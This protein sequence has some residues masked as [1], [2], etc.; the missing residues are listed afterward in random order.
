MSTPV[1]SSFD[2]SSLGLTDVTNTKP[3]QP[4]A[5]T[6]A[7][8]HGWVE[9]Q[10]YDYS[11]YQQPASAPANADRVAPI[12]AAEGNNLSNEDDNHVVAWGSTAAK[13]EWSDEFGEIGPEDKKLEEELFGGINAPRQSN[14]FEYLT[15][16]DVMQES[17]L[18]PNPVTAFANAGFHPAIMANIKLAGY[19]VPT[20]IQAYVIPTVLQGFDVVACAQTGSGKTAAFLLPILSKLMGKAKKLCAPKPSKAQL[21]G[22]LTTTY[23]AEPLVLIIAPTREL[24]TQIFVE[25]SRFCYRSMLR[26]CVVYGGVPP[27]TQREDL[28]KGCDILIG[29]PGR[30]I[31]FMGQSHVLSLHRLK[32]TVI[33]EADE[34]LEQ[35][36]QEDLTKLLKGGDAN[37]DSDHVFM[38]F[39]ATFPAGARTLAKTYMANDYVRIRIGR[40]GSAHVNVAQA[41][42]YTDRG[43]KDTALYDLLMSCPPTRTIIFVN[44]K[45]SAD[46]I[47]DFLYNAGL[48]STSIHASRTQREREDSFRSFRTGKTPILVATGVS[49]RGIDIRNVMHVINYDL[50]SSDHG[51]I[52]E[53]IHRIGRTARIGNTGLATSF[54]DEDR[55]GPLAVP[56]VKVLLESKQPIPDFLE[57]YKPEEGEE[58]DFSDQS[59]DE[60]VEAR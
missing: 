38:M 2:I 37:E 13:Y 60:G 25:A 15:K 3:A 14:A 5:K 30:L 33:D 42:V 23:R 53:Y 50:P 22:M 6:A 17:T 18:Q 47:D 12:D 55:D 29:T 26:P 16:V 34:M 41:F 51:G 1:P 10:A 24:A 21:T 49:A 35:D 28:H 27:K 20:P 57:Q 36:W 45:G 48:P 56:L 44:S 31:D 11:R 43:N 9:P 54:Y 40:P 46:R 32:F 58:L 4:G 59:E 52:Q 7:A 8:D 19:L 39:S